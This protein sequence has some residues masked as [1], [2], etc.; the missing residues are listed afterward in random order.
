VTTTAA[1]S[2][3]TTSKSLRNKPFHTLRVA[4]VEHLCDDAAAVT[5]DI[6]DDLQ[7]DFTF[8]PGQSL[9]LRK[10]VDGHDQRR[11]YSICA[12]VGAQPRVGV[13]EVPGGEFSTWLV[14]DVRVGDQVDVQTPS[15]TFTAD[16]TTAGRHVFIA[17]GSGITPVLSIAA[18]VLPN[19]DSHVTVFFGNRRSNSVMF[20]EELADLKDTYG[21]QLELVHVL[22]RESRGVDLFSGRLD[23]D[24]VQLLLQTLVPVK[25]VDHFWLCGP[26]GMVTEAQQVLRELGVPDNAVHQELFY[27]EDVP[28]EPVHHAEV[29]SYGPTSEVTII[30]DGRSTTL[31]LPRERAVLDSAQES[32]DD[33]PFACKGGVCGT[34][35]AK[36]TSGEADMRRNYALEKAEVE[37][38]FVLTCQSFPASDTVTVDYDA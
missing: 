9:T 32:R 14:R 33:L 4:R 7:A 26:F 11:S 34:C 15:G 36:V 16:P 24:R 21:S 37:A 6:P 38:G 17:A 1:T 13:R 29:T 28:P 18:S 35:R 10:I 5:F 25:Q 30:L 12:P 8:L 2:A 3:E 31:A 22:S 19:P 23:G 27:V 20:A